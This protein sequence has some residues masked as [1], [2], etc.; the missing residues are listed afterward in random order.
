MSNFNH[1]IE[2]A[3]EAHSGYTRKGSG[4]P[5]IVHPMEVAAIV[6]SMTNEDDILAAAVLHDVVEDTNVVIED[7]YKFFGPR[8]A[9]LVASESENKHPEL[10]REESWC[11]RKAETIEHLKSTDDKAVKMITLADKLSNMRATYQNYLLVGDAVWQRFNMKD[12]EKHHWYYKE[13]LKALEEYSGY[14]AWQELAWYLKAVF[15]DEA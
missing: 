5:Y 3:V 2:F 13:V 1:A 12:K 10:S 4:T 15:A 8:V 9:S 6:G 14:P 7:I 11:V